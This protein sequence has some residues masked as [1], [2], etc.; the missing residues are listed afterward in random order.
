MLQNPFLDLCYLTCPSVL[1][2][3]TGSLKNNSNLHK[4]VFDF[5]CHFEDRKEVTKYYLFKCT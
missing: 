5:P 4:L 1:F 3:G 2:H